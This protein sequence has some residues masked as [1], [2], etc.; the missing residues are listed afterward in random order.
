MLKPMPALIGHRGLPLLAPENTAASV[1]CAA[2]NHIDWI[3]VDVTMAGDQ[4]LVM[5]HD[6]T[7]KRFGQPERHLSD[8]DADALRQVDAG[9]WFSEKFAGEPLL[10]LDDLLTLANELSLNINLEIKTNPAFGIPEQVAAIWS[11]LSAHPLR[12]GKLLVSSF[13]LGILRHLRT[14]SAEVAIGV[15][16]EVLPDS[17]E[18]TVA[19][20]HPVSVHCDHSRLNETQARA[21]SQHWPLYCYTVN[22]TITLE[23]LLSWGISGVFSDRAHAAELR[24]IVQNARATGEH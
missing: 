10:L 23:K 19:D 11:K 16:F 15:L 22:D 24:A 21:V 13:D 4:S 1:R 12:N 20:I 8:L 5:M 6:L 2:E 7:L 17:L 14:L 18:G 9:A 3:E